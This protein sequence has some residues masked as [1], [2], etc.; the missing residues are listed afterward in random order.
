MALG[1]ASDDIARH[2]LGF[3]LGN[4][5]IGIGIGL[6]GGLLVGRAVDRL[7]FQ[8]GATDPFTFVAAPLALAALQHA[9]L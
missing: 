2:I 8:V 7:L 5:A 3:G 4:A 1:A 9:A 6:A